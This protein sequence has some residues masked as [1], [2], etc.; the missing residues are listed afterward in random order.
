MAKKDK[1]GGGSQKMTNFLLTFL[2]GFIQ[3][4]SVSLVLNARKQ[5]EDVIFKIKKGIFAGFFVLI[6]IF[7]VLIGLSIYLDSIMGA[8]SGV[9]YFVVGGASLLIALLVA[10]LRK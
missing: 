2:N 6:G 8:F 3:K 7:F 9:G 4:F 1:Q 10:F 5:V